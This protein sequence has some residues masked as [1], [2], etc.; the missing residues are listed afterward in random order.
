MKLVNLVRDIILEQAADFGS[1]TYGYSDINAKDD[2]VFFNNIELI[3]DNPIL[4]WYKDEEDPTDEFKLVGESGEFQFPSRDST[5]K[6]VLKITTN[7]KSFFISK[8]NF[9]KY[10]PKFDLK[11]SLGSV[12]NTIKGNYFFMTKMNSIMKSIYGDLTND[13]GEPMYGRSVKDDNCKT[14]SGVINFMGV[15]YGPYDKLV[16]DW[17]IL[18][19]FNTNSK[20]IGYL[21]NMFLKENNMGISN[22]S[23]KSFT[24]WLENNKFELFSPDSIHLSKLEELN[25]STLRPGYIREQIALLILMSLHNVDEGGITQYCPGSIEDTRNGRDLRINGENIYYQVK[26]LTGDMLMT[27]DGKYL[28]P[29]HS[30]KNYGSTV[31]R[32][33]FINTKG[34]KYYIFD[35]KD[36]VVSGGGKYVSFNNKPLYENNFK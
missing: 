31:D 16:S 6:P 4:G 36:Y 13:N 35:N 32:F 25:L 26:P 18:N 7:K 10:Y 34:D 2:I 15:K 1:G 8:D 27:D 17:S 28:I 29:S 20:V 21:V 33:I 19:Y 5:G 24:E 9:S 11:I 3:N 30:M 14:N 22:F 23:S 12:V